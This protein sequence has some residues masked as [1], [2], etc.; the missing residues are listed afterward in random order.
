MTLPLSAYVKM[1][2]GCSDTKMRVSDSIFNNSLS[3]GDVTIGEEMILFKIGIE[4]FVIVIFLSIG[5][6]CVLISTF[7]MQ[8]NMILCLLLN[9]RAKFS[10]NCK[11]Y[12][13]LNGMSTAD[14]LRNHPSLIVDKEDHV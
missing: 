13:M 4:W 5:I 7:F 2:L 8:S 3:I 12:C 9:G 1:M 6:R 11:K 10:P 14:K